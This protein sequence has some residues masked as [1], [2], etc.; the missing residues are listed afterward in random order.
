MGKIDHA[1]DAINHGVTNGDEAVDR[2]QRDTIDQLLY[3]IFHLTRYSPSRPWLFTTY[4]DGEVFF[5]IFSGP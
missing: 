5:W 1:D 3:K 4:L 2:P